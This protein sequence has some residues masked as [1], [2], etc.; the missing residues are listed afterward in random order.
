M[1]IKYSKNKYLAK[2]EKMLVDGMSAGLMEPEEYD[3]DE[4]DDM[5]FSL[6]AGLNWKE[7]TVVL[8]G[9]P[10]NTDE[11]RLQL[12]Y[13]GKSQAEKTP[14][15]LLYEKVIYGL[16]VSFAESNFGGR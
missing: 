1:K 7:K 4:W 15:G 11:I 14:A 12:Y 5:A 8:F 10:D 13:T 16:L 9:S 2:L 3:M 6:A